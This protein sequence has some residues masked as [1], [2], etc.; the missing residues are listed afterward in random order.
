MIKLIRCFFFDKLIAVGLRRSLYAFVEINNGHALQRKCCNF[1]NN[2]IFQLRAGIRTRSVDVKK[3]A[4]G[5]SGLCGRE[6]ACHCHQRNQNHKKMATRGGTLWQN[7]LFAPE[8]F[9]AKAATS[10]STTIND[11]VQSTILRFHGEHPQ[12]V[13]DCQCATCSTTSTLRKR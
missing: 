3:T 6:S 4:S 9:N 8:S 10:L 2:F 5:S 7:S 1:D 13:A 11:W 12:Q